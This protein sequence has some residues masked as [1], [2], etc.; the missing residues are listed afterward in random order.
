[1]QGT[2]TGGANL[3]RKDFLRLGG[4]GLAGAALFGVAGCG[5]GGQGGANELI[6]SWGPD[7]TGALTTLI[8]KYNQQNE[9]KTPRT[10]FDQEKTSSFPPDWPPPPPQPAT[11]KSA[12]PASPAPPSLR[13]SLRLRSA[14]PRPPVRLRCMYPPY[15]ASPTGVL[16]AP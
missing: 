5:G 11:P 16:P 13:K 14:P 6:F 15:H 9:G 12:A 10:S 1:M 2:R 7:D 3:S 8:D 4:A